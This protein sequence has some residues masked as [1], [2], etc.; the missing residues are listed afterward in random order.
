MARTACSVSVDTSWQQKG[1]RY[2]ADH[3]QSGH[4]TV[5]ELRKVLEIIRSVIAPTLLGFWKLKE[6]AN[7]PTI[8]SAGLVGGLPR[9]VK[10]SKEF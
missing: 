10:K 4:K 5:G 6:R 7:N 8:L 9:T 2:R 3:H 1:Y